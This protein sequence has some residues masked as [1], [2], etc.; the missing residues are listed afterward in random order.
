VADGGTVA[1]GEVI[2]V[3]PTIH[4]D[5]SYDYLA[6]EDPKPAGCEPVDLQSGGRWLGWSWTNVELRDD[7][8][9]FFIPYFHRGDQVLRYRLRAE[10]PGV[11]FVLPATGFAMYAPR[12]RGR[13]AEFKLRVSDEKR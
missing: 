9:A 5:A 12:I 11:F 7:R 4:A 1:V 8:L 6:F 2:E 13:S 3:A 10:T